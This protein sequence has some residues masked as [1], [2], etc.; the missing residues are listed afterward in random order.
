MEATGDLTTDNI[1]SAMDREYRTKVPKVQPMG[2][3]QPT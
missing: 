3:S 2:H 1:M